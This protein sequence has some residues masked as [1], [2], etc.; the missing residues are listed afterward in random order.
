MKNLIKSV[1][2]C[3]FASST[4]ILAQDAPKDSRENLIFGPKIGINY[5]NV[6]D[7]GN[8]QFNADG[9]LGFAGGAFLAIPVTKLLG[10]QP[11][12]MF[13]Q[14]G[15]HASGNVLGFSYDLSRTTNYL[16]IPIF[17]AIK[18]LT[19]LTV[20]V[21]PQFSYLISQKDVLT[22]PLGSTVLLQEFNNDDVRK[23]NLCLV[24]GI[25]AN[26][27]RLVVSLRGGFD[28]LSN[29]GSG[30]SFTP[31]YKN[32]WGQLTLGYRFY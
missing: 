12:L 31:R 7:S 28:M 15:L 17:F 24:A 5:A 30:S 4:L 18:P 16:D 10:V 11:E 13:S 32:V 2:L 19:F 14:K 6:Y 25:D 27:N 20:L 8:T 21:G 9:K 1:A 3:I 29:A 26:I 23:N 22:S